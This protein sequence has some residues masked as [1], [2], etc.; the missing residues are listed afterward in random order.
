MENNTKEY[1]IFDP[2][3]KY[4][5]EKDAQIVLTGEAFEALRS[6]VN[7]LNNMEVALGFRALYS[8][9]V[10]LQQTF[11]K[12]VELGNYTEQPQETEPVDGVE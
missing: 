3:K 8:L 6:T 4:T 2:Q 5:C 1:N 11:E 7:S 10:F 9:A 12:N